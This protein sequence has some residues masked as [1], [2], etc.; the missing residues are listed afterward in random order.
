MSTNETTRG[1]W[2]QKSP[3]PIDYNRFTLPPTLPRC[4]CYDP[5]AIVIPPGTSV[6]TKC[7]AHGRV[8]VSG[9]PAHTL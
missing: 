2:H 7:P 1:D 9:P 5:L 8:T 4:T 6:T 3:Q